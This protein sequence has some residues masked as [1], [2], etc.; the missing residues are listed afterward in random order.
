MIPS[1]VRTT[2]AYCARHPRRFTHRL[3]QFGNELVDPNPRAAID[4]L[5]DEVIRAGLETV[6]ID[7]IAGRLGP[8]DVVLFDGTHQILQNSDVAVFFLELLPRLDQ[9]VLLAVDDIWLPDDYPPFWLE[10]H[11]SEQYMLA[12]MLLAPGSALRPILPS[13]FVTQDHAL[14]ATFAALWP[15]HM[16]SVVQHMGGLFWL[17]TGALPAFLAYPTTGTAT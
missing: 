16:R 14:G 1:Q 6:D 15:E 11:Y 10:R 5:C 12:A 7:D 3:R 8:G 4:E 13:W 9:S 17:T 2:V